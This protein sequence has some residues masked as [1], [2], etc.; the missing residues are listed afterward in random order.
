MNAS[1]YEGFGLT[2]IESFE[3][4][5]PIL[6]S[7]NTAMK[8]FI[9]QYEKYT[10]NPYDID[11]LVSKIKIFCNFDDI[12]IE[13]AF[14]EQSTIYKNKV[15]RSIILNSYKETIDAIIYNNQHN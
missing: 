11:E 12:Q 6:A 8:E 4:G 2:V 7:N 13:E 9:N 14:Q 1:F 5:K 15:S 10:F 3:F